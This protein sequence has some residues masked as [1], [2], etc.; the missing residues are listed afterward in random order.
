MGA[1]LRRSRWSSV[2]PREYRAVA[3]DT[4]STQ[5]I[6]PAERIDMVP[7]L[8][9]ARPGRHCVSIDPY[10]R[11]PPLV[12]RRPCHLVCG[13]RR[14]AAVYTAESAANPRRCPMDRHGRARP[15][16]NRRANEHDDP[17][18]TVCRVIAFSVRSRIAKATSGSAPPRDSIASASWWR[19]RL[20]SIRLFPALTLRR[21]SPRV[22]VA[23]GWAP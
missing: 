10:C 20:A 1:R 16:P 9:A 19:R 18:G 11:W 6:S 12:R 22:T 5:A 2:G 8:A 7:H 13:V 17:A 23:C 14:P 3:V 4:W 21:C 15:G